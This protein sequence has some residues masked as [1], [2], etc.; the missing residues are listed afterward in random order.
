MHYN[1]NDGVAFVYAVVKLKTVPFS[2]YLSICSSFDA[3]LGAHVSDVV[4]R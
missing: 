4:R 1:V 2:T 3:T